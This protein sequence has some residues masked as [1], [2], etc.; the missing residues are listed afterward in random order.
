[1]ATVLDLRTAVHPLERIANRVAAR[2]VDILRVSL[3]LVIVGFGV[4]K[5]FP[6]VSPAQPL[7]THAVDMLTFG[8]VSGQAAMVATATVECFVGLT[9]VTGRLLRLGVLLLA[10]CVL[11][12]MSP[13]VLFPGDLFANGGPT[14]AA[15][16]ILKDIVLGAAGLVVAIKAFKE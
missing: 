2:G 16:Y 12:W 1:M 14:L 9:L 7:V 4:L 15:Q 8:V 5:F 3:G 6:G 13:L 11:G 10:G